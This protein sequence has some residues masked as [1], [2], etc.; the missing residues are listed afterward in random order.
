MR[1]LQP[2]K[3]GNKNTVPQKL[4]MAE[5]RVRDCLL[6]GFRDV[7]VLV[8]ARGCTLICR[9]VWRQSARAAHKHKCVSWHTVG[10]GAVGKRIGRARA[11][12]LL[13]EKFA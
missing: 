5:E 3:V 1:R 8:T 13:R 4:D 10:D 7:S 6:V 12:S 11:A 9:A 2:I